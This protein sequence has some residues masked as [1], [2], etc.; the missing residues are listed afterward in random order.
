[1]FELGMHSRPFCT[2]DSCRSKTEAT[3]GILPTP[4]KVLLKEFEDLFQKG[5]GKMQE[6]KAQIVVKEEA[7]PKFF[8]PRAVPHALK[9]RFV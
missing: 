2:A 7:S 4:L 5:L 1:M 6:L 3:W 8:K 9:E